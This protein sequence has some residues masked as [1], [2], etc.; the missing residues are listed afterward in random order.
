VSTTLSR[1]GFLGAALAAGVLPAAARATSLGPKRL[2]AG[3]RTLEVNGR[4]AQVFGLIGP[5]GRPGINLAPDEQFRVELANETG[6]RTLVHWHGQLPPW[7]QD[8]FPWP[9][10]P[11]I[12]NG[13]VQAYDYAPIAGTYWMHSHHGMQ[14][15]RLMTAPLIVHDRAVLGED[16]QEVVLMLDD[17]T[18]RTPAE[19]LAGLVGASAAT[20]HVMA[21]NAEDGGGRMGSNWMSRP[22][23]GGMAHMAGGNMPG[24]AM[25]VKSMAA[26]GQMQMDLSDVHYDAFLVNDRTLADPDVVRVERGGRIRLRIINGASASQFWIDLGELV[27]RVV[28]TDG[29]PVHPIAGSRFPIAMAQRLDILIDLPRAG[30]FRS[31]LAWKVRVGRPGSSS[32]PQVRKFRGL[33]I[34][35]HLLRHWTIRWRPGLPRRSR[36]QRVPRILSGQL[37]WMAECNLMPGPWTAHTGRGRRR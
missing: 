28:A 15:Q 4:P 37:I 30:A 16:R 23:V 3:T 13:A 2:V 22:G 36:C 17:F 32:R 27:G 9:Q 8:G 11:P 35:R 21:Q 10:T 5:D 12:G 1:R 25:A 14:E 26:P 31:L 19:V 20:A 6:V 24:M 34:T 7:T 33:Q 18:F 29:H